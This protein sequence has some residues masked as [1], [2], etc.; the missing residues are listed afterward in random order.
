MKGFIEI[1]EVFYCNDIRFS[2]RKTLNTDYIISVTPRTGIRDFAEIHFK[3]AAADGSGEP[4]FTI[5]TVE[6]SY[7]EIQRMIVEANQ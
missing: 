6:N 1:L 7:D 2:R 4:Y 5:I 3:E